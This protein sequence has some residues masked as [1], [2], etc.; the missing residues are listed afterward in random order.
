[1]SD[2]SK[3]RTLFGWLAVPL[4]VAAAA[5]GWFLLDP[6][7]RPGPPA[8]SVANAEPKDEFERRVRDYILANPE[9]IIEA[10]RRFETR[11]NAAAE[12]EAATVLK[13]RAEEILRDADSPVGGNPNGDVSLVEF[14]DYNC[15]YC[16]RVAAVMIEAEAADPQLRIVYKEFPILGPN[17]TFAAKAALAAHR[18][19]KYPPFHKALMQSQ[20]QADESSVLEVARSVGVDVERM[21]ADMNDAAIGTAIERNLALAQVLRITGTPGFVIGK[22]IVRGAIDLKTMQALIQ[23]ARRAE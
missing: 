16:R 5:A 13:M 9:I 11:Q 21:K 3:S 7:F 2:K 14:A 23:R 6:S 18:Q 12:S 1:M 17:S 8:L 19:G 10:V 22:E 4:I 15:P 20:G